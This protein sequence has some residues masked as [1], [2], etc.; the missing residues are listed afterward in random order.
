[1]AKKG[2]IVILLFLLGLLQVNYLY[3]QAPPKPRDSTI[4]GP[5]TFAIIL[6]I[7]DYKFVRDLQYADKDAELFRDFLK[8][9]AGGT[10]NDDNIFML[11]NEQAMSTNFWSKGING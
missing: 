2:F 7:S 8:S 5:Q 9:P 10:L 3:A 6:G 4:A 1:M 11:L